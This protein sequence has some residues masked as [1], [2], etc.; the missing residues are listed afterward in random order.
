M[1]KDTVYRIGK[2]LLK[3]VAKEF[4]A[5]WGK[6]RIP[7]IIA[8]HITWGLGGKTIQECFQEDIPSYLFPEGESVL[9]EYENV[10]ICRGILEENDSYI[11]LALGSGTINDLVK[12]A[13]YELDRGYMLVPTAPSV[14][15]YTAIGS[16]ISVDGFKKTIPCPPPEVILADVEM[17]CDAPSPMIASGYGDLAAK[18]TGGAD[19]LIADSLGIEPVVG[20]VWDMVQKDLRKYLGSPHALANRDHQAIEYLFNGLVQSGY[21]IKEYLDSRPASGAEHLMS[22]VWEMDHLAVGGEPVSHGFKVA[23]GTLS[24]TAMMQELIEMTSKDLLRSIG[25]HPIEPWSG[26]ISYIESLLAGDPAKKAIVSVYE[27]KFFTDGKIVDHRSDIIRRWDDIRRRIEKQLIPFSDLKTMFSI[28]G[29]PVQ[30]NTIALTK[31]AHEK[32]FRKAQ[33]IRKRYTCLD[34]VYEIGALDTMIDLI[35][36]S[37]KYFTEYN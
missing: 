35:V 15:G 14:D 18:I 8:D 19:W 13:S 30:P 36:N 29:C 17:L 27:S 37:K 28:V 9:A 11:G 6:E 26:R 23:I 10:E 5:H 33:L 21:A 25:D 1:A 4:Y 20:Y 32:G 2:N 12:L 22:H 24:T 3:D 31:E 34:L 7:V 16:A